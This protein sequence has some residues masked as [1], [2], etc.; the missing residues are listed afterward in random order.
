MSADPGSGEK[1]PSE[2][3]EPALQP[4]LVPDEASEDL[5]H[6]KYLHGMPLIFMALSLM[7]GVLTVALD[8]TIICK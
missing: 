3:V 6:D 5:E 2:D 4:A 7:I 8:N 1:P